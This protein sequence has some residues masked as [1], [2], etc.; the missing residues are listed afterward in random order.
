ME[1]MGPGAVHLRLRRH[2]VVVAHANEIV[3]VAL[4]TS[5]RTGALRPSSKLD[6]VRREPMTVDCVVDYPSRSVAPVSTDGW[7]VYQRLVLRVLLRS[8]AR[9]GPELANRPRREVAIRSMDLR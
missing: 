8:S 5:A 6:G 9:R 3:S 2:R 1:S 7:N 4:A